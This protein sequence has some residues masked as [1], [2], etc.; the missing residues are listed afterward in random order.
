MRCYFI[1]GKVT[2]IKVSTL[3]IVNME[4]CKHLVM[5]KSMKVSQLF[6]LYCSNFSDEYVL[7]E[8]NII[9]I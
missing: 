3:T 1:P 9:T 7:K 4:N 5:E 2:M 8:S 6:A